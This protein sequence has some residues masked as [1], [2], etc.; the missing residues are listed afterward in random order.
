MVAAELWLVLGYRSDMWLTLL[1]ADRHS[2]RT[3]ALHRKYD[4][5]QQRGLKRKASAQ[6]NSKMSLMQIDATI[7]QRLTGTHV[8]ARRAVSVFLLLQGTCP[9]FH[10]NSHSFFPCGTIYLNFRNTLTPPPAPPLSSSTTAFNPLSSFL[11][12]LLFANYTNPPL[13]C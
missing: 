13:A 7:P 4:N 8:S 5:R 12:H 9:S 10:F 6:K 11:L 1:L 3:N 2:A